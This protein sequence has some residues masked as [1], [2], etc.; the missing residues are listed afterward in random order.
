M[1]H[2]I[3]LSLTLS[4]ILISQ[5][6]STIM[7]GT[8]TGT[9]TSGLTGG[10]SGEA[11]GGDSGG[12]SAT[13]T[14]CN[15]G[16]LSCPGSG[17]TATPTPCAYGDAGICPGGT[18]TPTPTPTPTNTP[19][20][21]FSPTATNTSTA[22]P[23]PTNTSAPGSTTAPTNTP[24]NTPTIPA[25]DYTSLI[26]VCN[27]GTKY[28]LSSVDDASD[29]NLCQSGAE[30]GLKQIT[31]GTTDTCPPNT[32]FVASAA[33]G[34]ATTGNDIPVGTTLQAR[35]LCGTT[36][37]YVTVA[38][39]SAGPPACTSLVNVPPCIFNGYKVP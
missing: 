18:Y 6:G 38:T 31:S 2:K 30:G 27:N 33:S 37:Q 24:T 29:R 15:Y 26:A 35:C 19:T 4:L 14:S 34:T 28:C 32:V 10:A 36:T 39:Y 8:T 9:T 21:T 5:F 20:N 7:A 22:S 1:A 17:R 11:S 16:D 23:S 3:I 13:P 12:A 25:P